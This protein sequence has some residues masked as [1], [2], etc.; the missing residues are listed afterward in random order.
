MTVQHIHGG[1]IFGEAANLGLDCA[2]IL[3]YS[4][5]I[6]PLGP[7]PAVFDAIQKYMEMIVNYP[8]PHCRDLSKSLC[9]Y[10]HVKGK[11]VIFGNGVS[12][13]IYLLVRVLNCKRAV[14]PVPTFTEY[15]LAVVTAGGT[16]KEVPL[17]AEKNFSLEVDEIVSAISPADLVFICNPNNP[18]GNLYS[19]DEI[20]YLLKECESKGAYLVVDEAFI[21]FVPDVKGYSVI[22]HVGTSSGLIVFYSLTKFF[23]MPGLRLGAMLGPSALIDEMTAAKDPWNVNLFAQVGG[24]AA[25]KDVNHM[26]KT[27][28]LVTVEREY[29]YNNLAGLPGFKPY[30]GEA[31]FLL[32]DIENTGLTCAK[33]TQLMKQRGVLVRDCSSFDGL[34]NE[35]IRLAV[36][37]R[38]ENRRLTAEFATVLEGAKI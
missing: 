32:V 21:D 8:D 36:K 23:G 34:G 19:R 5:N 22:P 37:T 18:T 13:L 9:N 25:L 20:L 4:A 29:L 1:D 28:E 27:R 14:I 31:N 33:L 38:E 16:I 7:P 15:G 10:L 35:H 3:D 6:N 11:N 24:V 12:E 17:A 30:P 26:Q 2:R